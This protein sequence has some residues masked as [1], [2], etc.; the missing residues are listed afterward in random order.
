MQEFTNNS[1]LYQLWKTIP[2]VGGRGIFDLGAE[3]VS[4]LFK[5]PALLLV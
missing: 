4:L 2:R 3:N 5:L 1:S